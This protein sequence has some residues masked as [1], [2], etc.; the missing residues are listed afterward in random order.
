MLVMLVLVYCLGAFLVMR[1]PNTIVE[2]GAEEGAGTDGA[3]I[4]HRGDPQSDED[5]SLAA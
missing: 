3:T 5:T 1:T 2:A 4:A